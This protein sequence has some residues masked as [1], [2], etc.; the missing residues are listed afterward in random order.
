MLLLPN[1]TVLDDGDGWSHIFD[2]DNDASTLEVNNDTYN[3]KDPTQAQEALDNLK[4]YRE[5]LRRGELNEY[6]GKGTK[7]GDGGRTRL[8]YDE[9]RAKIAVDF[10][11]GHHDM[12]WEEQSTEADRIRKVR[13]IQTRGIR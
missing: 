13:A 10:H 2:L 1:I 6:E 5:A 12:D 3:L 9:L 7:Y 11:N 4:D 8:L